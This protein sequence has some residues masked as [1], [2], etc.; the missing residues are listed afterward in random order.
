MEIAHII[1]I[2]LAGVAG[3]SV[4]I[5]AWNGIVTRQEAADVKIE[6]IKED[7]ESIPGN[8]P[9]LF[10][11]VADCNQQRGDCVATQNVHLLQQTV[12]E[13]VTDNSAGKKR[14]I[15]HQRFMEKEIRKITTSMTRLE[16]QI[17]ERTQKGPNR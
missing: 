13:M 9:E 17:D 8:D 15:D 14:A 3:A 7:M 4:V 5:R 10:R 6:N 11:S 2:G 1:S 12:S 16:T